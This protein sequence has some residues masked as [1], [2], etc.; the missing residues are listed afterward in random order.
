VRFIP[1]LREAKRRPRRLLPQGEE[2]GAG[3]NRR[4]L[5]IRALMEVR[6][7][8]WALKRLRRPDAGASRPPLEAKG[9][10]WGVDFLGIFDFFVF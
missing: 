5:K 9:F 3:P 6:L 1:L 7:A 8:G 4:L 10:K 2:D